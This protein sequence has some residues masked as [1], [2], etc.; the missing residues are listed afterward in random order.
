MDS[1]HKRYFSL[2]NPYS[3][4]KSICPSGPE[5][6]HSLVFW[7]KNYDLFL[8]KGYG[9]ILVK[10]GYNLFF[11]FTLNS[12]SPV[13]EPGIPSLDNR[14]NQIKKMCSI[15][16]PDSINWRFDPICFYHM[17]HSEHHNLKDFNKI[18]QV[19]SSCGIKRC[20]TSFTD[21]YTK[22]KKR[23]VENNMEMTE[24]DT[25]RKV[26]IL[27]RMENRLIQK[28]IGLF[29]CCESNIL[30]D[31]PET[32]T[33]KPSSCISAD[34]LSCLYGGQVSRAKDQGQRKNKGCGCSISVDIGSYKQHPCYHNCLYC[35]ARP[36]NENTRI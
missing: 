7:S 9:D 13:L 15:F 3:G 24:L 35:Y 33:I 25:T 29:T 30:K 12:E 27:Q 1:I 32:S 11:N 2:E 17:N 5:H 16:N 19:I 10:M 21:M 34:I 18:L 26:N 36:L 14:L 22:V 20:I 23:C 6:V 4:K 31:L 28:K 8:K